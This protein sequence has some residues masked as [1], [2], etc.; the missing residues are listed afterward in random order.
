[1]GRT[2]LQG[3]ET[4]SPELPGQLV[5]LVQQRV[6]PG[7]GCH[8]RDGP[9]RKLICQQLHQP[10]FPQFCQPDLNIQAPSAD[11]HHLQVQWSDDASIMVADA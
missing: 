11:S 7:K 5:L 8:Q 3:R 6:G 4:V 9:Q 2:I 10:P 1:M